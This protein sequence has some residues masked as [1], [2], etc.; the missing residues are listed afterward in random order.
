MIASTCADAVVL[1]GSGTLECAG[2]WSR[3][4]YQVGDAVAL[5]GLN[6]PGIMMN[7][8]QG[9][10]TCRC[11]ERYGVLLV[12]AGTP[13]AVRPVNLRPISSTPRAAH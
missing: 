5:L 2:C 13:I 6:T 9:E 7:H 4:V 12:G 11:G 3:W 8:R 10:V 1:G